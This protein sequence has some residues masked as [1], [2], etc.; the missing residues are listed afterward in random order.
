MESIED[1]LDKADEEFWKFFDQYSKDRPMRRWE[2]GYIDVESGEWLSDRDFASFWETRP[3]PVLE[4]RAWM[5]A[6]NGQLTEEEV[7]EMT[8]KEISAFYL[9]DG[10]EPEYVYWTSGE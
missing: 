9:S 6:D 8:P 10:F 5:I 7:C 4:M 1:I 2:S 3:H